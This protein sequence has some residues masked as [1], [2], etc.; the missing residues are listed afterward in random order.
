MEVAVEKCNKLSRD[1]NCD[2]ANAYWL[3][4][5][6]LANRNGSGTSTLQYDGL[7]KSHVCFVDTSHKWAWYFIELIT[8]H[9]SYKVAVESW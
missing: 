3:E 6:F 8:P 1:E 9:S 7:M 4:E 5:N 2:F